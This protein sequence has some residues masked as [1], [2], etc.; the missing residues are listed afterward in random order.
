MGRAPHCAPSAK[1]GAVA[2][3]SPP[4]AR[5]RALRATLRALRARVQALRA[6]PKA[7]TPEL[8][9]IDAGAFCPD[10]GAPQ[11]RRRGFLPRLRGSRAST[12][13]LS[14][15]IARL[16]SPDS[17]AFQPDRAAPGHRRRGFQPRRR[18]SPAPPPLLSAPITR[19]RHSGHR[20]SVT[21]A[22]T[23]ATPG[24]ARHPIHPPAYPAPGL[25]L[26]THQEIPTPHRALRR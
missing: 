26:P 5:L 18:G 8:P 1:Q 4:L 13:S 17:G 11:H 22:T 19:L 15:P 20:H 2:P 16:T 24:R 6:S 7:P 21:L 10:R 3:H 25:F 14:A 23:P 9:G 12:P